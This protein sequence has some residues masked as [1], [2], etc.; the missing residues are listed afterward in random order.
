VADD[1]RYADVGRRYAQALFELADQ[2]GV[3][4]V[5]EA[6]LKTLD[7]AEHDHAELRRALANPTISHEDKGK[8]LVAVANAAGCS[9]LT[10]NFL[11]IL[12]ANLRAAALP[13]ATKAFAR[14]MAARRGAVAAEVTSAVPLTAAQAEGVAAALRQALGKDPDITTRVDPAILGGLKVRVGS[15]LFDS[16]L[17]SKL[18]HMKFALTRAP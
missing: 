11:G 15:R 1:S 14:L 8:V 18:D 17:K 16:S 10:R 5:V 7:Q 9:P 4:A 12:A 6:D 13:A 2:A 3:L